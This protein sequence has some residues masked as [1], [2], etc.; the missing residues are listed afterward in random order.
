[1]RRGDLPENGSGELPAAHTACNGGELAGCVD[2]EH[3]LTSSGLNVQYIGM[4]RV[5]CWWKIV[6]MTRLANPS[7]SAIMAIIVRRHYCGRP[8]SGPPVSRIE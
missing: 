4:V 5:T 8:C 2:E 6:L 3:R 7:Q 1:M